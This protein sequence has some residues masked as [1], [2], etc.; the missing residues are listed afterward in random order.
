MKNISENTVFLVYK[1]G[2]TLSDPKITVIPYLW[3]ILQGNI[4]ALFRGSKVFSGIFASGIVK[5]VIIT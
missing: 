3:H 1:M 2:T 4:V 5:Y